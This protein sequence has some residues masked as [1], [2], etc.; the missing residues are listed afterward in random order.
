MFP[1]KLWP[2]S[3]FFPTETPGCLGY[4]PSNYLI[5]GVCANFRRPRAN[6]FP[7]CKL[8]IH[9]ALTR[10]RTALIRPNIFTRKNNSYETENFAYF[11][12]DDSKKVSYLIIQPVPKLWRRWHTPYVSDVWNLH[13]LPFHRRKRNSSQLGDEFPRTIIATPRTRGV[14]YA[15][16]LARVASRAGN[17]YAGGNCKITSSMQGR[18]V[19]VKRQRVTWS[20]V[21]HVR[22]R[23]FRLKSRFTADVGLS[24]SITRLRFSW[25][26]RATAEN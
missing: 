21:C 5:E 22:T 17:G 12:S 2:R 8:R 7:P 15:V 20:V 24:T 3:K 10:R 19:E 1:T 14:H 25:E 13:P 9:L 16:N 23:R 6:S 11:S 4:F 18:R 26:T